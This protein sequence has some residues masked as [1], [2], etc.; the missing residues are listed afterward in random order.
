MS[1]VDMAK[2]KPGP[3]PTEGVGRKA[4]TTLRSTD[5]WKAWVSRY[6]KSRGIDVSDLIDEALLNLARKDR[7]EMPPKR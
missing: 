1:G 3:K 5:A 7:F 2:Q 4:L 6:A